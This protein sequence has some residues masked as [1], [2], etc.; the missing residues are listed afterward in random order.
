MRRGGSYQSSRPAAPAPP[1][2]ERYERGLR[3][4]RQTACR[5]TDVPKGLQRRR[6]QAVRSS[7]RARPYCCSAAIEYSLQVGTKRQLRGSSGE[8]LRL[9]HLSSESAARMPVSSCCGSCCCCWASS[10]F[11]PS[12]P[13]LRRARRTTRGGRA[14][15]TGGVRANHFEDGAQS[16]H[17]H[18]R[19]SSGWRSGTCGCSAGG[20]APAL[21]D[22]RAPPSFAAAPR[23]GPGCRR[24]V[25]GRR[26]REASARGAPGRRRCSCR[27]AV[28]TGMQCQSALCQATGRS[29]GR[30]ARTGSE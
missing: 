25:T 2:H 26:S 4:R 29:Y 13:L 30:P 10:R 23:A 9:Y 20:G 1:I 7:P 6:R 8:R 19:S 5:P 27:A 22:A 24:Y 16:S 11:S 3:L 21:R 17:W 28:A 15:P 14:A 12:P 18:H